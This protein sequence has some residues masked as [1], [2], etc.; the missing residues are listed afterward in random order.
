[1]LRDNGLPHWLSTAMCAR[2][3]RYPTNVRA[4]MLA[5]LVEARA[6]WDRD[7]DRAAQ[8]CVEAT[9]CEEDEEATE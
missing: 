9:S 1:M 2:L 3:K 7:I 5:M 4:D 8:R 6:Q